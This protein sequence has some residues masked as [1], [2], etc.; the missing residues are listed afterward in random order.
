MAL[1]KQ[2]VNVNFARG[3][4]TKTDPW[5]VPIGNFLELENSVFNK[6]GLLQKRNGFGIIGSPND[7][8][9]SQIANY[10]DDIIAIGNSLYAY[11]DPTDTFVNKGQFFPAEVNTQVAN[12]NYYNKIQADSVKA[13]NGLLLTVYVE[14]SQIKY[15]I[16]NSETGQ[17]V[18]N[19]TA[20][21]ITA[22]ST[23]TG[24]AKCYLF[25]NYFI[26]LFT[27]TN[28]GVSSIQYLAIDWQ[29]LSVTGPS[30]FTSLFTP[31]A[32]GLTVALGVYFDAAEANNVLFIAFN[33]SGGAGVYC[34]AITSTL[35]VY[36]AVQIDA[37]S[38]LTVIGSCSDGTNAYFAYYNSS[39]GIGRISAATLLSGAVVTVSGFPKQWILTK[40]TG[41]TSAGSSQITNITSTADIFPN[42]QLTTL[43]AYGAAPNYPYV[44]SVLGNTSLDTGVTFAG[45]NVGFSFVLGE[46]KNIAMS[47]VGTQINIIAEIAATYDYQTATQ[48]GTNSV[49]TRT[50]TTSGTVGTAPTNAIR[51]GV[52]LWSKAIVV[53]NQTYFLV[54]YNTGNIST[55]YAKRTNQPC[56]FLIDL[57]GN[58][59]ARFAYQNGAGYADRGLALISNDSFTG[60]CNAGSK[61][62][63]S[64]ADT[65]HLKVGQ[66]VISTNFPISNT[67]IESIDSASE[68]TVT[69]PAI[70]TTSSLMQSNEIWCSYL[71]QN[72]SQTQNTG[73][74]DGGDAIIGLYQNQAAYTA[75]LSLYSSST[76]AV[77]LGGNLAMSGG[78]LWNYDG[79]QATENNFLICPD[80]IGLENAGAGSL[81][82]ATYYYRVVYQWTDNQGNLNQSATNIPASIVIAAPSN[83]RLYIPT[84]R[85]SNKTNVIISVFRASSLQATFYRIGLV[86]T[87]TAN[88][89]LRDYITVL[90]NQADASIVG[91]EIL[92]SNGDVIENQAPNPSGA[93]SIYDNR[94]WLSDTEIENQVFFSKQVI[95]GTPIEMSDL[96]TLYV[97][98]IQSNQGTSGPIRCLFPMDD[99]LIIFKDNAIY[100]INGTGPDNTGSN[101][102]YSEPILITSTVGCANQKSIVFMQNGLMFQSNKGVWLLTRDMQTAYIG[103]PVE[104]LTENA[105]VVSANLIPG[106]NQVRMA[107]STGVMI[108]YDYFF[109]QWGSFTNIPAQSAIVSLGKHTLLDVYGRILQEMP[110]IYLDA[111][112]P[113]L[114]KF[115]TNWFALGGLQGFQRA[116]FLFL[117]GKYYTPHKLIVGLSYDFDPS[118]TQTTIINPI[119]YNAPWGND[120]LWGSNNLWG[121]SNQIEKWRIMLERQ[122]CDSV[123]ISLQEQYDPTIGAAAG[124]GLTLSGMNFIIGVKKSYQTIPAVNTVG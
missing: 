113:V 108:M 62:I 37:S 85:M 94:L 17:V 98:P 57:S 55:L 29:S 115:R 77:Q 69:K 50:C 60:S 6:Q 7:S 84:L 52:G 49:F 123:Q 74:G 43:P 75:K 8:S 14:E 72:F 21:T 2:Q 70:A 76:N 96:L 110:N 89:A 47:V 103:A 23:I 45:N 30:V 124:A 120:P 32:G 73:F 58:I 86:R 36:S 122:K 38:Q 95:P 109:Q 46:V 22:P 18:V 102:Q 78:V 105:Q 9:V 11:N 66:R 35:G 67:Y 99:K 87:P 44:T 61:V 97:S 104:A 111:G 118:E 119:N 48:T 101:S 93:L 56:Y 5:Q 92:Y 90:D 100:Y 42:T 16:Q 40:F 41:N 65:T 114:M 121:G 63:S 3:L 39:T 12:S 71:R 54:S 53:N 106:T 27:T 25:K 28:A 10:N 31:P 1:Q 116:Y 19:P 33:A 82:A 83:V 51:R 107:L 15:T 68:I 13:P 24:L 81:A 34:G 4:D 79:L 59:V 91:N 112:N 26:L 80:N 117:L 20:V 88:N 64:I